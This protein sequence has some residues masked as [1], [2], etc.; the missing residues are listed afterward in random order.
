MRRMSKEA[1]TAFLAEPFNAVLATINDDGT[2]QQSPVSTYYDGEFFYFRSDP[3]ALKLRNLRRDP[4][5]S[6]CVQDPG[7]PERY[8]T[9][10]GRSEFFTGDWLSIYRAM[11]QKYGV[12]PEEIERQVHLENPRIYVRITPD[13]ILGA[14]FSDEYE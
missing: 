8:L 4:R 2:P 6:L 13:R 10:R 11:R 5:V 3:D 14:D 12:E 7:P 1:L 9:V